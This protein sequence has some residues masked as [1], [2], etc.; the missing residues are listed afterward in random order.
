MGKISNAI[1]HEDETNTLEGK[2]IK[3][4]NYDQGSYTGYTLIEDKIKD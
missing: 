4:P 1:K 2:W 3:I